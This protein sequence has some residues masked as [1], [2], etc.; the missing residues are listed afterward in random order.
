MTELRFAGDAGLW[1]GLVLALLLAGAAAWLYRRQLHERRGVAAWAL[2]ALRALTVF[3][4]VMLLTQPVLHHRQVIGELSRLII[5][6]DDSASMDVTDQ[7]LT[8]ARQL[9][10]AQALGWYEGELPAPEARA[11]WS[12]LTRQ[13]AV[14]QSGL[15]RNLAPSA[16]RPAAE[17]LATSLDLALSTLT[18]AATT[19][20]HRGAL[21]REVWTNLPGRAVDDLVKSPAYQRAPDVVTDVTLAE[22]PSN[23]GDNYG[24]RLT[25]YVI[26]PADGNYTFW[27]AGDDGCQ[28]ALSRSDSATPLEVIAKVSDWTLSREWER[29]AEQKSR[30]IPLKAGQRYYLQALHKEGLASDYLAIGWQLPDG[31]IERPIP[32]NRLATPAGQAAG[33][34]LTASARAQLAAYRA[35]PANASGEELRATLERLS[36]TAQPV[37]EALLD[38]LTPVLQSFADQNPA[39]A[40][41]RLRF[42]QSSRWRR[43]LAA[44]CEGRTPLLKELAAHHDIQLLRLGAGTPETVWQ[45]HSQQA[46]WTPEQV[47]AHLPRSPAGDVTDLAAA[48]AQD[49]SP[50]KTAILLFT[51]GQHNAGSSPLDPAR[52]LGVRGIPLYAVGLGDA[53]PPRRLVIQDVSAPQQVFMKDHAKGTITLADTMPG[54]VPFTLRVLAGEDVL[55]RQEL[56]SQAIGRRQVEFDFPVEATVKQFLGREDAALTH[57]SVPLQLR[58]ELVQPAR[59]GAGGS[60]GAA[61]ANIGTTV[62]PASVASTTAPAATTPATGP[63]SAVAAAPTTGTTSET[64]G[65]MAVTR[66]NR[67]LLIDARPRWEWRYLHNLLERDQQWEINAVSPDLTAAV[68]QF[69]RGKGKGQLPVTRE[70]W[71]S[72]DLILVGDVPAALLTKDEHQWLADFVLERGGGLIL[73]DGRHE[74]LPTFASTAAAPVLPVSWGT[75]PARRQCG[76]LVLTTAGLK[77]SALAVSDKA[78]ESPQALWTQL[79]PPHWLAPVTALAGTETLITAPVGTEQVPVLVFRRYGSGK[80]LYSASEEFWRWRYLDGDTYYERFWNQV[81]NWIMD[82]PYAV[83]DDQLALDAGAATYAA[84]DHA[85][86][87]ARLH[88]AGGGPLLKASARAMFYRGEQLVAAVPFV[89]DGTTGIYRAQSAALA[90]GEYLVKVSVDGLL[91]SPLP[92]TTRFTV[93]APV[94]RELASLA[95]N[96]PL[97]QQLTELSGGL[98][99]RE[100]QL[101]EVPPTLAPL[102]SGRIEETETA[103]W[104]SGWLF[105]AIVLLLTIEWLWRRRAG[106]I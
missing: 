19:T 35:L 70:E 61:S 8:P 95:C 100:E 87:R 78:A 49:P 82:T 74:G 62:V 1:G 96:E 34:A 45:S 43:V 26:A 2:P 30:P 25:G 29:A 105:G 31:T 52:L 14:L 60:G 20:G 98:Y 89:A 53:L 22:A 9:L 64:L 93:R 44:L 46:Q 41:A 18:T 24:E 71:L 51:D 38:Q 85:E 33:T 90:P 59:A 94:A 48:L 80:V 104:Q 3:I 83:Q 55:W 92:A 65:M 75:G 42:A 99:F 102:S 77:Q 54:A 17:E 36:T 5:V 37:A 72:Y 67:V 7:D 39:A 106:L 50:T 21:L 40:K 97:L 57:R 66:S 47:A 23:W 28:L 76:P 6:V 69:K 56:T 27:L 91:P 63:A 4:L 79:P 12:T 11:A 101:R 10:A 16:L 88:A 13:R 32:G 81:T 73:V 84:G 103:L 15:T 58:V 68:M 86:I